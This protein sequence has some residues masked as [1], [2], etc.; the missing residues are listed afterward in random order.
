M[1]IVAH[2]FAIFT[3]AWFRFIGVDH[4][5][6]WATI[7]FFW[8][9]GPFQACRETRTTATTQARGLHLINDPI[10]AILDNFRRSVPMTTGHCTFERT[11]MHPVEISKDPILVL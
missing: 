3:G 10:T 6:G 4:Q 2:D 8:H 7:A 11:I 5:I 1:R 9:E